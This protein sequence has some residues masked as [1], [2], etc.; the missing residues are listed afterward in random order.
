[1]D[2]N[3]TYG[4]TRLTVKMIEDA[5]ARGGQVNISVAG[6]L[7]VSE[8]VTPEMVRDHVGYVFVN[9]MILASPEVKAALLEK[10]IPSFSRIPS[11][12]AFSAFPMAFG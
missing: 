5:V 10:D 11:V 12:T 6:F 7:L 8:D 3:M 9:G 2:P 4:A 1:M